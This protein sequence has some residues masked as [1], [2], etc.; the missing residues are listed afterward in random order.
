[1]SSHA[2]RKLPI[3]HPSDLKKCRMQRYDD[4]SKLNSLTMLVNP[5]WSLRSIKP[6]TIITNQ[7][8]VDG[9]LKQCLNL[10]SV[11][12]N[13]FHIPLAF[14]LLAGYYYLAL[15]NHGSPSF[16]IIEW[17]HT[18]AAESIFFCFFLHKLCTH[19]LKLHFPIHVL[20]C[21]SCSIFYTPQAKCGIMMM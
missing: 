17:Y 13:H 9:L 5:I 15:R 6:I 14:W 21:G 10:C 8:N 2:R 19:Q 12:F 20:S 11:S 7:P 4:G 1:M 16:L 3:A 18:L